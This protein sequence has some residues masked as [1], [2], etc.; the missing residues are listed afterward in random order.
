[1]AWSHTLGFPRIGERRELKK[2]TEAYW[3]GDIDRTALEATGSELR[4]ANWARQHAAGI[5]QLPVNDF[6]FY[7]HVLDMSCLVGNV[8]ARF[9]H[10]EDTV[11]L[12]TAFAMARGTRD[13]AACEMTKWF[14][15]NYHYLVPE[16]TA[17]TK[18]FDEWAEARAL[19]YDARPVLVGP[20]TYLWLGKVTDDS[21]LDPFESGNRLAE[22]LIEADEN[23]QI[24]DDA[25]VLEHAHDAGDDSTS[26]GNCSS[27][28]VQYGSPNKRLYKEIGD[29]DDE[30][31]R[32]ARV[33]RLWHRQSRAR[34]QGRS[35]CY[36]STPLTSRALIRTASR[37]LMSS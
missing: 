34:P 36:W 11:D 22:D 1:M 28:E 20:A 35:T 5:D 18:V 13:A 8:P 7:D 14:D 9:E 6:S 10:R 33:R 30:P 12:D 15:T 37:T 32:R 17:G 21:G 31:G 29:D 26:A 23:A 19:G 24:G 3:A 25:V 16:F 27:D 2:A 4:R